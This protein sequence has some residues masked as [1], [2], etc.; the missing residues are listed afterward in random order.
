M[1]SRIAVLMVA[2]FFAGA[3]RSLLEQSK[4][5]TTMIDW[6]NFVQVGSTQYEFGT[7]STNELQEGDLGPVYSRVKFKVSDNVCDPNYRPKDGDAAF[8]EPGTPVYQVKGR[9]PAEQLAAR[10]NGHI[11]VYVAVTKGPPPS[12]GTP[13]S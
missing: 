10:L 11:L 8:L 4:C 7:P 2:L 1:S 5:T 12:A 9:P 6:V 3:C 13:A